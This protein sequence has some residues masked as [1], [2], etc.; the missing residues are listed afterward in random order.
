MRK[1]SHDS[2]HDLASSDLRSP[3][4]FSG[5]N[6]DLPPALPH[7]AGMLEPKV[8]VTPSFLQKFLQWVSSP[9]FAPLRPSQG[10][11]AAPAAP[12]ML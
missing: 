12:A 2:L 3:V 11:Q 10:S 7:R 4:M 9:L 1:A 6:T 5:L 8:F